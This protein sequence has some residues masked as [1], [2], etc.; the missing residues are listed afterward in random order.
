MEDVD[1]TRP[2]PVLPS[3]HSLM[4]SPALLCHGLIGLRHAVAGPF[5]IGR[6]GGGGGGSGGRWDHLVAMEDRD[7]L[8]SVFL[9]D[10]KKCLRCGTVCVRRVWTFADDLMLLN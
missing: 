2:A 10:G 7:V 6:Q 4:A 8:T 5:S 9:Q 1:V 3:I